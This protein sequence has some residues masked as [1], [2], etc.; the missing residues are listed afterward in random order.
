MDSQVGKTSSASTARG[1][2]K[3]FSRRLRPS[4]SSLAKSEFYFT[5]LMPGRR[6][7]GDAPGLPSRD[8]ISAIFGKFWSVP[9][10]IDWCATNAQEKPRASTFSPPFDKLVPGLTAW[11]EETAGAGRHL[12][13]VRT[14]KTSL[15]SRKTRRCRSSSCTRQMVKSRRQSASAPSARSS[16]RKR[17]LEPWSNILLQSREVDVRSASAG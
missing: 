15:R 16:S 3:N 4:F 11:L 2:P 9:K 8:L 13:T 14:Q 12:R 7:D 1:E 17:W 5:P 10:L 6:G